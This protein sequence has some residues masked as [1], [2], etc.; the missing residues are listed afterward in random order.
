MKTTWHKILLVRASRTT[1][2]AD[3]TGIQEERGTLISNQGHTTKV[4][5]GLLENIWSPML[6]NLT[7]VTIKKNKYLRSIK[8]CN[9]ILTRRNLE[10][11]TVDFRWDLGRS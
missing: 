8:I 1:G 7:I 9:K 6:Q 4:I 5:F 10:N 11:L 2:L 3:S